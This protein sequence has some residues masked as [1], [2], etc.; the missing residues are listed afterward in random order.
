MP[1]SKTG[2]S[3]NLRGLVHVCT[4]GTGSSSSSVFY[5][6]FLATTSCYFLTLSEF[7]FIQPCLFPESLTPL[8]CITLFLTT[9]WNTISL[10]SSEILFILS[11]VLLN[12]LGVTA[13]SAL[14]HWTSCTSSSP[15][16]GSRLDLNVTSVSASSSLSHKPTLSNR[17]VSTTALPPISFSYSFLLLFQT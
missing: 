5:Q 9:L 15:H 17:F 2:T 1:I 12:S 4:V 8:N 10:L 3:T 16:L 13:F 14:V 7:Q 6:Q 11:L